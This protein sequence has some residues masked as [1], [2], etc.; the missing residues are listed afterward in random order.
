[1]KKLLIPLLILFS[2]V[3]CSNVQTNEKIIEN[4]KSME[5]LKLATGVDENDNEYLVC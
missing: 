5:L 2:C 1:M 3:G 4:E